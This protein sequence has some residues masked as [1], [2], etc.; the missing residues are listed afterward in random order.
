[1]FIAVHLSL[2]SLLKGCTHS[3][4]ETRAVTECHEGLWGLSLRLL[5][6]A[7]SFSDLL[8]IKSYSKT[9]RS[10]CK[11]GWWLLWRDI[12]MI[13]R[14]CNENLTPTFICRYLYLSHTAAQDVWVSHFLGRT[15]QQIKKIFSSLPQ[16]VASI[17]S[18]SQLT[19]NSFPPGTHVCI[20]VHID[21][22]LTFG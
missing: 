4:F 2:F 9:W 17:C 19:W 5:L 3:P 14:Y 20:Y 22:R 7:S 13:F 16:M 11:R 21:W 1:M 15:K 12:L 10:R 6:K 18:H 8:G